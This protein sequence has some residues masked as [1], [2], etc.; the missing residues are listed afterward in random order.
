VTVFDLDAEVPKGRAK[1]IFGDN[2][3]DGRI[4]PP[5]PRLVLMSKQSLLRMHGLRPP[6]RSYHLKCSVIDGGERSVVRFPRRSASQ[7]C[8][9]FVPATR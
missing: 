1:N 8:R 6:A 4:V 2:R 7:R 5:S 9:R 3:G